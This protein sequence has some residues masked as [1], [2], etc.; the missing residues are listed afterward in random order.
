MRNSPDGPPGCSLMKSVIS[1]TLECTAIQQSDLVL[2]LLRSVTLI[3]AL[4]LSSVF[5]V[6]VFRILLAFGLAP[7]QFTSTFRESASNKTREI[8]FCKREF[9]QA[10]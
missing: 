9:G 10:G 7:H 3:V 6:I 1:Q 8:F 4:S 2:C 5:V